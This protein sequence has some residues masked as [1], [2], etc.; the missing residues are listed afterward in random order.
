MVKKSNK[1]LDI[2]KFDKNMEIKKADEN[3][4]VWHMPYEEPFK[5]AGFYWF[6]QDKVYRRFPVKPPF[7]LPEGVEGL[8]WCTAGGQIKFRT[9]SGKISIRAKLRDAGAMDHMAQ[10]GMSGFDLYA[11]EPCKETFYSVT[12]FQCGATEFTY[13]LFNCDVRKLRNFTINF[14]LYKGVNEVMIGLQDG[15]KLEAPPAYR[16]K[17]PV[18][19]YGTSITQGGC[20]S[21]PGS[22]CTNI[23]SRRLNVP[24]IN[25]GFSGSGRGEPDVAGN[26]SLIEKPAM[27]VLDYEANC[28]NYELFKKTLP[29]FI[30]ILRSAHKKTPILVISKNRY[31]QEALDNEPDNKSD[32]KKFREQCKEL[33]QKLVKKLQK[34]GD[35]NIYFLDGSKLLGKDYWECT[36]DNC[37]PT[38]LGFFRMADGIEPV[39]RKIL[40]KKK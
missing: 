19:V 12:R 6:D 39:I 11:G 22:C 9:D 36:V 40:F 35:K 25:L 31:G 26:I 3:G 37:H 29:E 28:V 10:T 1:A 17:K 20:A 30:A 18:V 23:L 24:F 38:D 4:L 34:A 32:R 27:L 2:S 14:P 7:P 16:I 33:Q 5:L 8:S 21:R 15:A 13:E